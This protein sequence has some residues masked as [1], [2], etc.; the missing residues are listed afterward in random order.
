MNWMH[1]GVHPGSP[2][3]IRR[4]L[5]RQGI[6]AAQVENSPKTPTRE[7]KKRFGREGLTESRGTTPK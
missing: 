6:E 5:M 3:R 7:I 1:T 4:I 2:T